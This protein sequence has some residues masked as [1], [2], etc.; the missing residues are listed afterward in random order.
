MHT[1]LAHNDAGVHNSTGNDGDKLVSIRDRIQHVLRYCM[2]G[3]Y[4][5]GV[6]IGNSVAMFVKRRNAFVDVCLCGEGRNPR[7]IEISISINGV[8]DDTP[9]PRTLGPCS[10]EGRV[11]ATECSNNRQS[12]RPK[13]ARRNR[14]HCCLGEVPQLRS[15][16]RPHLTSAPAPGNSNSCAIVCFSDERPSKSPRSWLTAADTRAI[17]EKS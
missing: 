4:E 13:H 12:I 15:I 10:N 8:M 7:E 2:L 17:R 1:R 14:M 3:S 11:P 6:L 16:N 9:C 5:L